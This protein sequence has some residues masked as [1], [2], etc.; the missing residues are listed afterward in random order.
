MKTIENA[1]IA[2]SAFGQDSLGDLQAEKAI[3][4]PV[5]E[6]FSSIQG[7]GAWTGTSAFFI[8]LAGCDVGCWF[9]DT[10]DSWN[11]AKHPRYT[12]A[13]LVEATVAAHPAIAIVTGG[14]PTLHDLAPLTR[15]LRSHHIRVHLETSGARPISGQ[16]D[17]VTLSPKPNAP[18]HPS[19]YERAQELK[20]VVA[21]SADLD[22]AER[23]ASQVSDRVVKYLQPEWQTP[24]SEALAIAYVLAHPEWRLSLQTHKWLGVR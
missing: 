16:F 14:E 20:L 11:A 4:Y 8:R 9:C 19:V 12:V 13:E 21:E 23:Q 3:A 15:A 24:E 5:V 18:P 22:W 17:W 2:A 1:A 7:E 6:T 10:K